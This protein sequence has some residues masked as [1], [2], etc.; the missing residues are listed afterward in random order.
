MFNFM[1]SDGGSSVPPELNRYVF[2]VDKTTGERRT[3]LLVGVHGDTEAE[4]LERAKKDYPE[5]FAFVGGEEEQQKFYKNMRYVNGE[6]LEPLAPPE[7]TAEEIQAQKLAELDAEYAK[8]FAD[9]D[10]QIIRAVTVD[11]D[12][13][14][15]NELRAEKEEKQKEYAEKRGAL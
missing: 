14:Y 6:F 9:Y 11:Q 4:C 5:D 15:A 8:I 3:S 13:E 2:V 12:E 10:E 1:M 7:P